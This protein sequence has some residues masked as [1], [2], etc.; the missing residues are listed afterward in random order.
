MKYYYTAHK[1]IYIEK[2]SQKTMADV[3]TN[4]NEPSREGIM[5]ITHLASMKAGLIYRMSQ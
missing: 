4:I 1:Q 2:I 3:F 5:S